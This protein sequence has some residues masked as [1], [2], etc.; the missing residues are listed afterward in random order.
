MS[1]QEIPVEAVVPY[2]ASQHY[3]LVARWWR[4][5]YDGD[6][7]PVECLPDTGVVAI[8]HGKPAAAAFI[9]RTN[10]AM[11]M[12]HLPIADPSLGSGRRIKALRAA[13][14][15]AVEDAKAWL[16]GHGFVWCCT[17]HAVVA[18]VYGEL[19]LHC[20]GEADVYFLPVGQESAE[21]LK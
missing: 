17:D 13:I 6:P 2:D 5:Y 9:Y 15:G 4:L 11:A 12:V 21:F 14:A 1:E 3:A 16:N 10:A 18:R 7:L 19:G 8:C 20:P